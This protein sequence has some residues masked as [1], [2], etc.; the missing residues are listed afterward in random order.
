[1]PA[2]VTTASFPGYVID[3][4]AALRTPLIF[5]SPHSGADYPAAFIAQS[6]LHRSVLRRSEDMH[7]DALI[8]DL[9]LLGAPAIRA[10]FPRAFVDANREPFELDPRMFEGRLPPY[11]NTRSL[12]VA[13][14]LGSIPRIVGDNLEIYDRRLPVEEAL[15]RIRHCHRPYHAAL[16]GLINRALRLFGVSVLIDCHSMPSASVERDNGRR[17]DFVI[18]DRFGTSAAPLLLEC[19][20]SEAQA[21]GYVT[22]RNRPYAGGYITE[23][24]G[25]PDVGQHALQIEINRALYMNETTGAPHQGFE[26]L[27]RDIEA[28]MTGLVRV[29]LSALAPLRRAAE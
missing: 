22:I 28:I 2:R 11:A 21:R 26:G 25:A 15:E 16:T 13:G 12:R 8:A 20:E 27:K 10:L 24:Y 7:V 1:L 29:P 3:E 23:H 4:P 6:R 19:I 17:V 9:P 14:G 5:S 18:G